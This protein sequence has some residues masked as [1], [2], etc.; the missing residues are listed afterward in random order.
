R[1]S[2]H[3]QFLLRIFAYQIK[4]QLSEEALQGIPEAFN[5]PEDVPSL[6]ALRSRMGA[7]SGLKP[8]KYDCCIDSCLAYTGTNSDLTSCPYCKEDR[9]DKYGN[10]RQQYTH[11][12]ITPR[13][14]ALFQNKEISERM[15]YREDYESTPGVVRD[16][17][18]SDQYKNLKG[19]PIIIDGESVGAN[20]FDSRTDIALGL[21]TDGFAPFRRRKKS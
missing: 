9:H 12:P 20:F 16:I 15:D 4:H 6:K 7:L 21:S 3:D 10:P 8:E 18:D 5:I 11:I 1:L 13:L 14:L 19:K 2:E 17:Q